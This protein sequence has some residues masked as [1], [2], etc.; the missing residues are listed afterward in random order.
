MMKK[1][2]NFVNFLFSVLVLL[3]LIGAYFGVSYFSNNFTTE[4][5]TF[6]LACGVEGVE[7]EKEMII[8]DDESYDLFMGIPYHFD[9]NYTF[10]ANDGDYSVRVIPFF[11]DVSDFRFLVNG[12]TKRYSDIPDL[13]AGFKI[14]KNQGYFTFMI[15]QD[16]QGV[17]QTV[18]ETRNISEVKS[19]V[20]SDSSYFA[21]V[22][23]SIDG[24][25]N[26]TLGINVKSLSF[27]L[28]PNGV[29]F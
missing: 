7:K 10:S 2:K 24:S 23:S 9:V 17:L 19:F 12:K 5:K 27:S 28:T 25:K 8:N 11:E 14:E 16:L 1:K 22:V 18:Y 6:Y 15:T 4:I 29:V 20:D 26:L 3:L 13:S 21:I